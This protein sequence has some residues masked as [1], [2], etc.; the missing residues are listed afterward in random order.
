V[1]R[2][3]DVQKLMNDASIGNPLPVRLLRGD[4]FVDTE[5]LPAEL[6]E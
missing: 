1:E 3:D 2:A 4:R 5:L 6:V